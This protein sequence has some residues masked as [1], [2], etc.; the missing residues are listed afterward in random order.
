MRPAER[1]PSASVQPSQAAIVDHDVDV[2]GYSEGVCVV[3][4]IDVW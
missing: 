1:Y 4:G 2:I 3:S